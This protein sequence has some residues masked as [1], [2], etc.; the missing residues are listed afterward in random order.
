MF[1]V[2]E[3][4]SWKALLASLD[5]D[6]VHEALSTS[7]YYKPSAKSTVAF[8]GVQGTATSAGYLIFVAHEVPKNKLHM[9][10]SYASTP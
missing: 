1:P 9:M 10:F 5:A 8:A 6:T 4:K 2:Y 3:E 7:C